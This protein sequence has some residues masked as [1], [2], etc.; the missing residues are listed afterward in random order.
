MGLLSP[1]VKGSCQNR[2]GPEGLG[3]KKWWQFLQTFSFPGVCSPVGQKAFG[4][5]VPVNM[6]LPQEF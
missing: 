6:S 2:T 3:M 5:K 1:L 4:R